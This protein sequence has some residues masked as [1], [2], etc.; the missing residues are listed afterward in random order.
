MPLNGIQ[1]HHLQHQDS[2]GDTATRKSRRGFTPRIHVE[3]DS[4]S[5]K[6]LEHFV[7]VNLAVNFPQIHRS[8]ESLGLLTAPSSF[9]MQSALPWAKET[10]LH[11][12]RFVPSPRLCPTPLSHRSI[13]GKS[14]QAS[15][16]APLGGVCGRPRLRGI[17]YVFSTLF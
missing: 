11:P 14:A 10:L 2:K 8:G 15:A 7:V 9:V 6:A 1:S 16:L 3:L 5:D 13:G 17:K 12:R 4:S